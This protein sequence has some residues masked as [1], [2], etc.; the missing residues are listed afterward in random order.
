MQAHTRCFTSTRRV[1]SA[2][3]SL[4]CGSTLVTGVSQV[5]LPSPTSLPSIKV[6]MAFVLEAMMYK[7][8]PSTGV[9]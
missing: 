6:V 1:V 8:S 2:S 4:N 9:A 3:P 7:V 5:S